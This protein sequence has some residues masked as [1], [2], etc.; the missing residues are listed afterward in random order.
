MRFLSL[1]MYICMWL[2]SLFWFCIWLSLVYL[3]DVNWKNDYILQIKGI[4]IE[5][6]YIFWISYLNEIGNSPPFFF[7][8]SSFSLFLFF[9]VSGPMH[10]TALLLLCIQFVYYVL[11]FWVLVGC[12]QIFG[13]IIW[14]FLNWFTGIQMNVWF[15]ETYIKHVSFPFRTMF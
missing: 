9:F 5:E 15:C 12:F 8:G 10:F 11:V 6:T 14:Y 4:A 3:S 1:P 2:C 13:E 7:M